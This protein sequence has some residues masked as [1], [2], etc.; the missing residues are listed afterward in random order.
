MGDCLLAVANWDSRAVDFYLS[1]GKP[2]KDADCR[3]ELSASWQVEKADRA[4]WRPD[5]EFSTYQS[6]NLVSNANRDVFLAG[7]DTTAAGRDHV[8]LF[9]VDMRQPANKLLRKR[10]R[11]EVTLQGGNHFRSAG[12]VWVEQGRLGFL[13]S[14]HDFGPRTRINLIPASGMRR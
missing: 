13:S 14:E 12:G 5:A 4:D 3:F 8:D 9:S 2:L 1:N 7:F 11:Q 10:A 6:V